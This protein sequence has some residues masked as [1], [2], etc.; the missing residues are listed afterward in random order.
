MYFERAVH[1]D[2]SFAGSYSELARAQF[3]ATVDFQMGNLEDVLVSAEALIRQT[4]QLD[5]SDSEA[6]ST[7]SHVS[8]LR[9]DVEAAVI[10]AERALATNPN[11][12]TAHQALGSALIC[13]GRAKGGLAALD[14]SMRLDPR[15]PMS[16][17]RLNFEVVGLYY[18]HQYPAVI[19]VAQRVIRS[20]PNF[21]HPYR[22]LA[23]ALGQL[24]RIE[25]ANEALTRAVL[26]VPGSFD[27]YVRNRV[28]WMR[29]E[30]HAHML[31]GLRRAGWEG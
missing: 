22:W 16:A 29:P 8:R 28:R 24:G 9:G 14:T 2:P 12:A 25:E 17:W 1:L 7:L 10:E 4:L 27:M 23:A 13:S 26:V 5:P 20:Y 6:R 21:P 30:D 15:S 11:L 31:E 18:S 3:N 19:G